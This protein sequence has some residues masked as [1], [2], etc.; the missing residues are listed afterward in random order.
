M[1]N[2]VVS[3]LVLAASLVL[4]LPHGWCCILV[5]TAR[6]GSQPA[7]KTQH[8]CCCRTPISK[9]VPANQG[10]LPA[11][12]CP[13]DD[14]QTVMAS[15]A[16]LE[17]PKAQPTFATVEP[18]FDLLALAASNSVQ[19][20]SPVHPSSPPVHVIDCVWLC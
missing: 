16:P 19:A 7:P 12:P 13:C 9:P 11:K 5:R 10:P 17:K 1:R 14:R 6:A 15:F 2:G 4:V 8:S 20:Y 3:S 18:S